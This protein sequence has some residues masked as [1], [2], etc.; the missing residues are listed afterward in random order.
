[1]LHG[2]IYYSDLLIKNEISVIM[3]KVA[4]ISIHF[5]NKIPK[6]ESLL[7]N[8]R[9]N[10][11]VIA[12]Q[13]IGEIGSLGPIFHKSPQ[14]YYIY[15]S[16]KLNINN[17]QYSDFS[18]FSHIIVGNNRK[19]NLLQILKKL[20]REHWK[21]IPYE[22]FDFSFHNLSQRLK[23]VMS[24]I[25]NHELKNCNIVKIAEYLQISPGYFSQEFKRETGLTFREFMQKIINHYE[26]IMFEKLHIPTKTAANI[27]GYSELSSFSRS[28]K[29]RK[30][31]PPSFIK[32]FYKSKNKILAS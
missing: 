8:K 6:L 21:K 4:Q 1:M 10:F 15:Y 5:C 23:N 11:L 31:Y 24:Y 7:S 26:D 9:V 28:Y 27:L 25:E 22:N 29:K 17:I 30:G 19:S 14:T 16:Y 18:H 12:L 2:I 20:T 3:K 32:N 13:D